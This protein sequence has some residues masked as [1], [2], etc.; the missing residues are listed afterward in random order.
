VISTLLDI[1]HLSAEVA[2]QLI[3]ELRTSATDGSLFVFMSSCLVKV[4]THRVRRPGKASINAKF[5]FLGQIEALS[6]G[7][8]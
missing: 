4:L 7:H 2:T 8:A 3:S 5:D 6:C 1:D